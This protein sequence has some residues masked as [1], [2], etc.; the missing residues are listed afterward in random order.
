MVISFCGDPKNQ[1]LPFGCIRFYIPIGLL[2]IPLKAKLED[3]KRYGDVWMA[4]M[5]PNS[6]F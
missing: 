3:Q 5:T 2:T 1:T 4:C 6:D